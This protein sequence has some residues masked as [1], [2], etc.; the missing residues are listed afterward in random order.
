M[1]ARCP[2][3]LQT[4]ALWTNSTPPEEREL[5]T[6]ALKRLGERTRKI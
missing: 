4:S 1:S 5:V 2:N 3:W 6:Q